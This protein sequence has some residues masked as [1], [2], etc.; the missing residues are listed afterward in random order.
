MLKAI[1]FAIILTGLPFITVSAQTCTGSL[2]DPIINETFG[3]GHTTLA[4]YKTHFRSIGGCPTPGTYTLSN[5]LFGCGDRT[6]VQMVGDHTGDANG[7]YMLVNAENETGIVYQ[8]S[9]KALCGST[10]YQFG[11]WVTSVMTKLTC[12]GNAQLPKLYYQVKTIAGTVLAA[13]STGYLPL[14]DG[15]EFKFYSLTFQTPP[16]VT[17]AMVSITIKPPF[18]CGSAFALDDITLRACG[19]S[20]SALIDG[21]PGPADVCA[22]YSNP[23][24]LTG[25]YSPGFAD[26]VLQWQS[27]I[28][29]ARTW[30][31]IPGETTTTYAVPRRTNG[32]IQYRITIVE[33]ANSGSLK[34]RIASNAILTSIHPVPLH[35]PP[36]DVFGCL[37]KNYF[38]P[39]ADQSALNVLWTGPNGYTTV[40]Y[41]AEIPNI[42]YSD[43][44]LYKLKQTFYFGCVSLDTFNLKV[45][46]GTTISTQPS[47]P[48]CE[49]QSEQ[50]FSAA[51]DSVGFLW[52]PA[53]GLSNPTIPN[54]IATPKDST[55]YMVLITNR[56]GCK[57]SATLQINVYRNP[58]ANAGPDKTILLGDTAT[59][60][61]LVKGTGVNYSWTPN[62]FMN[63]DQLLT[64][65]VYPPANSTYTLQVQS[66]LGCGTASDDVNV[67]VYSNFAIP[68]AFTP[69][70]DGKN[71]KFQVLTLDN[72]KLI[73]LF[74][75]NRWGQLVFKA[76]GAYSGWDGTFKGAPQPAGVYV[77]H[78]E[79]QAPFRPKIVKKGTLLL[80]R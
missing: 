14:V 12:G 56:Y 46:P 3:S 7:N 65:F 16:G 20:I 66:T 70:G 75:Y 67:K 52:I 29:S 11:F 76:E 58:V 9:A 69:N 45:F 25:S 21:S 34:C 43:T 51:T 64:P 60:N 28:D 79:I 23:F 18:G 39:E 53:A 6:W 31:D 78:L 48:I 68:N 55:T 38:F 72:Y 36:H 30:Q 17:D 50:L 40:L 8:D 2:G 32:A 77:Y 59:L 54:P 19:P 80:I 62:T 15:K 13:D 10:V 71:D 49:G 61:G 4:A 27:S 33:R 5:F 37:G 1:V 44:G 47:T 35:N 63:N 57:D 41:K 42:Q 73:H 24:V 26:P 22:D 74:I